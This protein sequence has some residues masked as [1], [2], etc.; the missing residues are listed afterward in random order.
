MAGA[1]E[2]CAPRTREQP[3]LAA[4]SAQQQLS[5]SPSPPPDLLPAPATAEPRRRSRLL[6]LPALPRPLSRQVPCHPSGLSAPQRVKRHQ[7]TP[8]YI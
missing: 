6:E 3:A 2:G 4:R 1:G 8:L 5:G 7:A